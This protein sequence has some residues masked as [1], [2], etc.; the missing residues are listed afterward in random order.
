MVLEQASAEKWV[1]A[2]RNGRGCQCGIIPP[3]RSEHICCG[4]CNRTV[5][6]QP[7]GAGPDFPKST[8]RQKTGGWAGTPALAPPTGTPSPRSS[9]PRRQWRG[10]PTGARRIHSHP[11]RPQE[12]PSKPL[13]QAL[14]GLRATIPRCPL[15]WYGPASRG[16]TAPWWKSCNKVQHQTCETVRF[17]GRLTLV[18]KTLIGVMVV[19]ASCMFG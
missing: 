8:L 4:S 6:A 2:G 11:T 7:A 19:R 16:A 1:E 9:L 12:C 13:R 3:E 18:A 14:D 15:P 17:Y 5:G 10:V